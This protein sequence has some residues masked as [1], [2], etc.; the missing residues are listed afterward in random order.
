[1]LI[2]EKMQKWIHRKRKHIGTL[3]LNNIKF[4]V[5]KDTITTIRFKKATDNL[6]FTGRKNYRNFV[7]GKGEYH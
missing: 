3:K 2:G 5:C 6:G 1:M 4:E 7:E